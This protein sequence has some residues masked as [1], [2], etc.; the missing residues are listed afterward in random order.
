M[1]TQIVHQNS[2]ASKL[3]E[4]NVPSTPQMINDVAQALYDKQQEEKLK[5]SI[6]KLDR[7]LEVSAE[8]ENQS[9]NQ[10]FSVRN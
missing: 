4:K 6:L 7:K 1:E 2:M 10:F 8:K 3:Q 9:N 5:E